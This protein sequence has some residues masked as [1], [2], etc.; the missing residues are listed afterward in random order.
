MVG[1]FSSATAWGNV[2]LVAAS[3]PTTT[4][5]ADAGD[6]RVGKQPHQLTFQRLRSGY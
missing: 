2:T 6:R 1:V 3:V 4:V 5:V